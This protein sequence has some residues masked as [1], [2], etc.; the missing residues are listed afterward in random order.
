MDPALPTEPA[1]KTDDLAMDPALEEAV[2]IPLSIR[3]E[4]PPSSILAEVTLLLLASTLALDLLTTTCLST[5]S[6]STCLL[7]SVEANTRA[8][9]LKEFRLVSASSALDS[10]ASN[11][12]WN[13]LTRM[14]LELEICSCSSNWRLYIL[15]F[16][17]NLSRDSWR[18]RMFLRSSSDCKSNSLTERSFLCKAV[19]VST[20][21]FFSVDNRT[22]S[23][24][25][26]CSIFWIVRRLVATEFVSISSMRTVKLRTSCSRAFLTF[27]ALTNL[28]CSSRKRPS[29]CCASWLA[30]L[31]LS[32]A[33][34]NSR[35]MSVYS[36][37][38]AARSFSNLTLALFNVLFK[39]DNS[40]NLGFIAAI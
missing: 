32:S 30:L 4:L 21:V 20:W 5:S 37:R 25:I 33:N 15:I 3:L 29:K 28:A 13:F 11:S 7:D 8:L 24:S 35:A 23:S 1:R 12:L 22:S 14:I 19:V 6:I 9:D 40:F 2:D 26:L 27:S 18:M 16:S 17:F 36:V 34:F 10:A 39:P 38:T 31:A